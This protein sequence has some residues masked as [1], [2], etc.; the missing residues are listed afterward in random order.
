MRVSTLL[1]V[2]CAGICLAGCA[3]M[4]VHKVVD[5]ATDEGIRYYQSSPYV[6]VT[7]DNAGGLSTQLIFLPDKTKK[8][9][10]R[11]YNYLATNTSTLTFDKGVLKTSEVD[12]DSAAVPKAVLSAVETAAIAIIKGAKLAESQKK[13]P[14]PS[15]PLPVLFK[16]V[17]IDHKVYLVG[18]KDLTSNKGIYVGTDER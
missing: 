2:L 8:M 17:V 15:I 7:T 6:L 1:G 16:V 10:A 5:D 18:P 11:P 3:G 12:V 13:E 9:S 14:G 4:T